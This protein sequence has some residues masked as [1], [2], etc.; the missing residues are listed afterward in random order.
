[1]PNISRRALVSGAAGIPVLALQAAQNGDTMVEPAPPRR[2]LLSGRYTADSLLSALIPRERWKPFPNAGDRADW[3]G[4]PPEMKSAVVQSGARHLGQPYAPLAATLFLEFARNGNRSHYEA[5]QS[6]RRTQLREMVLAECVEGQGR[7]LDDIA[8]GVWALCEET[9]WGYPAHMSLQKRGN[10]LPDVS[11]PVIDLFAAETAALLAWTDYLLGERL[12]KVSPLVRERIDVEMER[13][14][15]AVYRKRDDFW[16][17]GLDDTRSV[18]NWNPWINSNCLAC[19]LL[20]DRDGARRARTVYKIL[21]SLDR[22]LD[23]YHDDG[24][25]D[26]GPG[27][28]ARAGGSLFD[29]LSSLHSASGGT[30]DFYALPLVREIGRYIYRAHIYN[31]WYVNF[32]DASAKIALEGDLVYRYGAAIGDADMQALG[33][34]AEHGRSVNTGSLG[35]ALPALFNYSR[36]QKA[37]AWQPLVRDVWLAGIQV[38]AARRKAAS[39]EGFY[40]AALGGHNAESHNHNDVGNFIAYLDGQPVLVDIGVETY[41]AKTFS[42]RRYEIWTMQSAYHNLPTING[43]MQGDGRRFAAREVSFETSDAGAVFAADIAGAYPAEAGVDRWHRT[44]RLDRAAGNLAVVDRFELRE[45]SGGIEM[46]LMT[47]CQA[48]RAA[49]GALL[50]SGGFLAGGSVRLSFE[51]PAAAAVHIDECPTKDPRLARVWGERLFRLRIG[52]THPPPKG[53]LRFDLSKA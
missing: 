29:C 47:P 43:V 46:N 17:M 12:D 3:A 44:V 37:E 7:F 1:M 52:W 4:L 42:P 30:I 15:L 22:F 23:G 38:A 26:E 24:G 20:M 31:D 25:C 11:E 27:Y 9:F 16:W 8:N 39:P 53:E 13:R 35:R 45:T 36:V 33:A 49:D 2:R 10:G 18:N 21:T 51:G 5:V 28:W 41:T 50:L 32:A 6:G 14:I 48:S 34:F 19:A 40:F